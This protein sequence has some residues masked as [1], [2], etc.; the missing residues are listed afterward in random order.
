MHRSAAPLWVTSLDLQSRTA[1]GALLKQKFTPLGRSRLA[2]CTFP[3]E[4]S[5]VKV[6]QLAWPADAQAEDAL[7]SLC[8][9]VMK[10]EGGVLLAFPSGFIPPE[11][12]QLASN[13]DGGALLGPHTVLSVPGVL[14]DGDVAHSTGE[15][16]DVQVDDKSGNLSG[17]LLTSRGRA[18][19]QGCC[20]SFLYRAAGGSRFSH[21]LE[22]CQRVG[23][24]LQVREV[25]VLLCGRGAG[26]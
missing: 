15:D 17:T 6:Y 7:L 26:G 1:L 8:M 2:K 19:R 12:L 25:H 5:C 13:H 14:T 16:L 3:M 4:L 22:V 21:P 20:Y 10:R 9:V 23:W 11:A 24:L 18:R